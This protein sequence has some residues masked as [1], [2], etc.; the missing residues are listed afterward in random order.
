MDDTKQL[1][2]C[3]R[4]VKLNH[5][6]SVYFKYCRYAQLIIYEQQKIIYRFWY[7]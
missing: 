3:W 2:V 7:D 1:L 6:Q 5:I 4:A